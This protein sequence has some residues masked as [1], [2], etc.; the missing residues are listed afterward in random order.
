MADGQ[1]E[2]LFCAPSPGPKDQLTQTLVES[3]GMTC[4]LKKKKLKSFRYE[5][6]DGSHGG[7]LENIF[8]ASSPELKGQ[9]TQNL[10]GSIGVT[11]RSKDTKSF[12]SKI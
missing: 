11:C 10:V 7:P 8:C 3:I 9:L 5:I 1:L 4:K 6:Q 2:N 12:L